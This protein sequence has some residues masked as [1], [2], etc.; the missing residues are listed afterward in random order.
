MTMS[1]AEA[2]P[3]LMTALDEVRGQWRVQ[4]VLGGT[5]LAI[6][7]V[8]G[9]LVVLI[10]ADNF[11]HPGMLGRALLATILWGVFLATL[12]TFVIKRLLEDRRD[13]F[14]AALVEQKYPQLHN[15]LINALQLGR[16]NQR[17]FSAEL[18]GAIVHDADRATGDLEMGESVDSQ[19]TWRAA[20]WALGIVAV[21]GLYAIFFSPYFT[22]GLARLLLP[23]ADIPPFTRTQV[24]GDKIH[25]GNVRVPQGKPVDIAAEVE[26]V[27]P[28][29]AF[30]HLHKEGEGWKKVEMHA[31]AD[32]A[33]LFR[34]TLPAADAS[35]DY[36]VTAGDGESPSFKATVVHP[37]RITGLNVTGQAPKYTALEPKTDA[38]TD[39]RTAGVA[40][41]R[42]DLVLHASKAL[43]EAT[44][45]TKEGE[46]LALEKKDTDQTWGC[47]FV[48][49][50]RDARLSA[51]IVGRRVLASTTYQVQLR[52]TDGFDV[53]DPLWRP[54]DL[55]RDNPPRVELLPPDMAAPVRIKITESLP[56][57]VRAKDDYGLG[58]V[59][60]LYA[61]NGEEQPRH[62][63][64]FPHK[65]AKP[66]L[67]S[68]DAYA[69]QL[70]GGDFKLKAGDRIDCWA[71]A[72]DRNTITGPSRTESTRFSF[73][74]LSPSGTSPQ[75]HLDVKDPLQELKS[76]LK[77]QRENRVDT[78]EAAPFDR[79]V[80]RQAEINSRTKDLATTMEKL[81]IPPKT[82]VESLRVLASGLMAEAL[83]QLE[84][85][86]DA[87]E[88]AVKKEFRTRS[89]PVQDKI[90]AELEAMVE[91]LTKNEEA[92]KALKKIEK[93]DPVVY[94]DITAKI[95]D[96]IKNLDQVLK[97]E[98]EL[99][100]KFER[101]PK[102][103][104]QDYKDDKLKALRELE[105]KMKKAKDW[106]KG[107]V[108]ELAKMMPGFVDDFGLR[109]DA[110]QVFEEIEKQAQRAKAEK[111]EVSLED[112][113]VGLATKM[114]EDLELWLPDAADNLKWVLE[115][116]LNKKPTKIPEMPLPKALEDLVGD[117]LQKA[118][119]FD[120]DA[121][122]ITSAWGDNMDQAGWGVGDGPISFFSAKGKTGNDLPN[123]NEV[124]GR[125]GDGRRGKSSG[126]M[127]GDTAR[128]L[129]G[130]PTPARVGKEQYE[131]G[132]LKQEGQDDPK[133]ATGGGKKAG[134]GKQGLQGGTP[135][136]P[137][138][139]MKRLSEKQAGLRE[140]A[141]QVAHKLDTVGAT[142]SRL[143]ESI[144]LMKSVE[145]D[146]AD[147][148]YADA[149]RKRKEAIQKLRNAFTGIDRTTATQIKKA[150]HL[151]EQMKRELLQG[152]DEG[153][154]AGY[155]G[156]L[157]SYYKALSTKDK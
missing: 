86:K 115:E 149:F 30:V 38:G 156:L 117:L 68:E 78:A 59:R 107:S 19:S 97:D 31:D 20:W 118:D 133:G 45:L 102:R 40:G 125:S 122:D 123:A 148:R 119:E 23:A 146:L 95:G 66:V 134:A 50:A 35:F 96:L 24:P 61:V 142:T 124:S 84:S 76:L 74:V 81:G 104:V 8:L 13:D 92:K 36:Y 21:V 93:K 98:T 62:L 108:N 41:T 69:W 150:E 51:D 47:S 22:N 126:Q 145:K 105:E 141:E 65:E 73:E 127:V 101:M 4:Q 10:A 120:E 88:P 46:K 106:A 60:L 109:K 130:R 131:P 39:G 152:A 116:P 32:R 114:K 151:P 144:E 136:D 57:R 111:L 135:P 83:H 25:P 153:Y 44:L 89:L 18:I 154:P 42:I 139:N 90:I 3:R 37:P 129:K 12:G 48:I 79:I 52:D 85:G 27:I 43:Q 64:A 11:L 82:M 112:M 49:W 33:D 29:T 75:D 80:V 17:G 147:Q 100:G 58:E 28:A 5:L 15:R 2:Y 6:A 54:I 113:G 143:N 99:A 87:A 155:E 121:D 53:T 103:D 7:G 91:R 16:G 128:G 14:F 67:D 9:V 94:K 56:L 70:S 26:G 137:S 132:Q 71:E 110:N 63:V 1:R 55:L 157:K 77:M 72:A 34:Y 140:K 138:L